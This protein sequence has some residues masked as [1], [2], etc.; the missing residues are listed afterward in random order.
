[1]SSPLIARFN[2]EPVLVAPDKA[3]WLGECVR[4]A[5]VQVDKIE[6][7][8]GV[9][10]A[11]MQDDFWPAEGSWMRAF[12]PYNVT[13]D[14]TLVIPIKGYMAHDFGYQIFDWVTGYTYIQKAFE[15][16]MADPMVKRIAMLSLIHI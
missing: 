9:E 1:M 11:K 3:N 16:G 14:G 5:Q 15:R 7:R 8:M 12:R 2:N 13:A 4:A 10:P 6:H